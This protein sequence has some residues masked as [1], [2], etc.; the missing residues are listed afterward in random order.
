MDPD[1]VGRR[2]ERATDR[3]QGLDEPSRYRYGAGELCCPQL[4]DDAL[5]CRERGISGLA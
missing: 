1:G 3:W 5:E 2:Q 4:L